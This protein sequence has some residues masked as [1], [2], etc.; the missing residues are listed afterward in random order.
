MNF[1]LYFIS[2]LLSSKSFGRF[3]RRI[4][5]LRLLSRIYSEW[6]LTTQVSMFFVG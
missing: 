4:A 3:V 2:P 5:L 6:L 1:L